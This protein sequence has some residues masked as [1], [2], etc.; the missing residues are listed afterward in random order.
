[1][2]PKTVCED[3]ATDTLRVPGRKEQSKD[4]GGEPGR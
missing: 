4:Q 2:Y 3:E 1:M